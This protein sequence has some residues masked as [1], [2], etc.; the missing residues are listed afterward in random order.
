VL[1]PAFISYP[2]HLTVLKYPLDQSKTVD[3]DTVGDFVD[4]FAAGDVKPS[5]KSQPIPSTQDG[6]VFILV[7]DE[8]DKVVADKKKDILVECTCRLSR[9][10]VG[11]N[12]ARSLC[13]LYA[14]VARAHSSSDIPQGAVTARSCRRRGTPWVTASL[15]PKTRSPSRRWTPPR[16]GCIVRACGQR[17]TNLAQNDIPASAGFKVQGFPTIK[18]KPAGSAAWLDYEGD[19]SVRDALPL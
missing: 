17:L 16:C 3:A 1:A 6:S 14:H 4:R 2:Y 12:R 9:Q 8:F 10:Y 11:S 18:F 7:A 5:V 15:A 19:R 13:S